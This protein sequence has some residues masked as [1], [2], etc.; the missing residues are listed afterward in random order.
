MLPDSEF[1][2][3]SDEVIASDQADR[4]DI[5]NLPPP[6]LLPGIERTMQQMD[7]IRRLLDRPVHVSSWYRSRDLNVLVGGAAT[8]AILRE[9]RAQTPHE[10]VAAAAQARLARGRHGARNSSHTMG[11]AVDFT[12][13]QYGTVRQVHE[14]LAPLVRDLEIDQLILEF[15][16]S[17][18]GGWIHVG[19]SD[20]PRYM[21]F[22]IDEGAAA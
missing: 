20:S 19:F 14:F 9:T 8:A 4:Y 16:N 2:S 10:V 21:V 3:W 5:D 7:R 18:R 13:R 17:P 6:E 15:P 22:G 11:R 12:C 1:F